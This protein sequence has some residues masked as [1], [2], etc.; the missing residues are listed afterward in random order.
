MR[1]PPN[2]PT[3]PLPLD[4]P[5][6]DRPHRIYVA[7]TNHCNRSC[8]WCSTCSSPHG[9]T[10]LTLDQFQSVLPAAGF[11]Q[12]QL[13]G[14]EPTLHPEFWEFVRVAR[15]HPRCTHLILCTNGV[16]LPRRRAALRRW[17]D[18]LGVPVT[19][20]LSVNHHLMEHDRRL[21]ELATVMREL[22]QEMDGDRTLVI[23]VRLRR[24]YADDDRRVSDAVHASG[25]LPIANVF[26]LQR[27]GFA[28]QESAWELPA[29][30][31]DRF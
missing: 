26:Y 7:L 25:L 3:R 6:S 8:P 9:N 10:W 1:M 24:G 2:D 18:R 21:L 29:P 30:V 4:H 19:L 23:N 14:G 11:F 31:S 5:T 20:K 12:V 16:V 28:S 22:F 15:E 13:E 17:L 27:Y